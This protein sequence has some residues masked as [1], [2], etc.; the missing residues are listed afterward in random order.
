MM[1]E[2]IFC[3]IC[4]TEYV[5]ESE[6]CLKC[7]YP[8][9]GS[10]L[11]KREFVSSKIRNKKIIE[12]AQETTKY[13]RWILF[14]IGGINLIVSLV[15]IGNSSN[16]LVAIPSLVFSLLI[17]IFSLFSYKDPFCFLLMGF[18]AL[19]LLYI[20]YGLLEPK[21]LLSGFI[22]KVVFVGGFISGLVKI[23]KLD[24]IKKQD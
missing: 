15:M 10:E 24:V 4:Y 6:K 7:G 8:F 20:I 2:K 14:I 3:P 12:E 23:R 9:A 16:N 21:M 11:D 1:N 19:V 13:S 17:I 22:L 18:I 5:E